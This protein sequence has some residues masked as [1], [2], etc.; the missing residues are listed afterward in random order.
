MSR[1][2]SFFFDNHPAMRP[3]Q[4]RM[5]HM[6]QALY[7]YS[8]KHQAVFIVEKDFETDLAS[9]PRIFRR[10]FN[11][12]GKS[13]LP[14]VL[15]DKGYED[16]A[17]T[18]HVIPVENSAHLFALENAYNSGAHDLV[19]DLGIESQEIQLTRKQTD[20]LFLESM[21]SQ[22]MNRAEQ[23][24]MYHAVRVGGWTYWGHA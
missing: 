6:D 18:Y 8:D 4:S 14:A 13:R 1:P 7:F 11:V 12:N 15:H 20:L 3:G 17:G 24:A 19:A 5:W 21:P 23:L 10:I 9:I 2:A 22:R 16:G